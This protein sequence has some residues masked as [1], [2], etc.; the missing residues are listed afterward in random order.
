MASGATTLD[1]KTS[2]RREEPPGTY[3]FDLSSVQFPSVQHDG[4][5]GVTCPGSLDVCGEHIQE[6][7]GNNNN[8]WNKLTRQ[9]RRKRKLSQS[10]L[11]YSLLARKRN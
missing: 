9:Q 5:D 11:F 1:W 3:W 4:M 6:V 2:A 8:N 7:L 10:Q